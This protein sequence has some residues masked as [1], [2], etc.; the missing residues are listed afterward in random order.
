MVYV[1]SC[2]LQQ[3]ISSR[4]VAA[5]SCGVVIKMQENNYSFLKMNVLKS[6][7]KMIENVKLEN[8]YHNDNQ[9][10]PMR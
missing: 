2:S 4:Y 8:I 7:R 3:E 1:S 5:E 6:V 10:R 9:N